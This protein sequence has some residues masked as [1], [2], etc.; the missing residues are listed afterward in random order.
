MGETRKLVTIVFADI[1]GSTRLGEELD[2]E[3]LRRVMERYFGDMRSVLEQHGGTVEKFI[4]DAVM[5]VFGIPAAHEDDALRAVRAAVE[6]RARLAE[7]NSE[8]TH[9]RGVMLAVR[10]GINT[11]EVVA[12]D[13]AGGQFYATGDAVNVAARLEQVADPGEILLGAETYQLV[14]DAVRVDGVEPLSL[15]GKA[16]V[17][18]AYRLVEVIEGAPGVA[19][20]FETRFV[21]REGQMAH[22]LRSFEHSVVEGAPVLITVL[23]AAGLGKTR[24]AEEFAAR[25]ARQAQVLQGRCLSYGEGITFWP[26]Q[27]ILRSLPVRPSDVPRP[28][29]AT[30]VEETFWA[31]RKLF[32]AVARERPLLIVVE[33]IHWAEPTLLDLI[34]HIVEWTQQAPMMLLCLARPDLLDRRPGWSGERIELE[35]LAESEAQ[36]LVRELALGL[37]AS[38]QARAVEVADGNP[39]FLEQMLALAA[40][41]TEAESPVPHTI[42]ALLAA[43][44][45]QLAADERK[46]LEAAS[47]VGK[48]FW[49]RALLHLLGPDTE[50]SPLLQGLIRKRLIQPEQSSF[51]DEDAFRFG[52]ILIREAAYR[53][54][55]KQTR[56]NLHERFADW[57][58]ERGTPYAEI[59]GYH[60]EQ[61]V[62]YQRDL[63]EPDERSL[64]LGERAAILLEQAGL[65]ALGRGDY[66][67]A[68]NLLERA[69]RLYPLEDARALFLAVPLGESLEATGEL[70]AAETLY[71]ETIA[72]AKRVGDRRAQWLAHLNNVWLSGQLHPGNW[73]AEAV[74]ETA[75]AAVE[76]FRELEDD[77]GLARAWRLRG[78]ADFAQCRYAAASEADERALFY[79]RRAGD[80]YAIRDAINSLAS[81]LY[82]GPTP[83]VE[84]IPRIEETMGE[85]AD[86]PSLKASSLFKLAALRAVQG[87]FQE[88]RSLYYQAKA[89]GEEMG[90]MFHLAASSAYV[91]EIGL[92]AGDAAFAER[93]LTAAYEKLEAMGERGVRSTLAAILAEALLI[94][95][96]LD[97]AEQFAD[98]ALSLASTDDIASQARG[99]AAKAK[100]LSARGDHEHAERL[101]RE[102]VALGVNTDDLFMQSQLLMALAEVLRRSGRDDGAI[103]VLQEAVAISERKGIVVTADAARAGLA[104]LHVDSR[105]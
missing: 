28:E 70:E 7:L 47:I 32:E 88:A 101:G 52:H 97:E 30:S 83:V 100:V 81:S 72:A 11:G 51:P 65:H 66:G 60:L 18:S 98:V 1:S 59:V 40:D 23:G 25:V 62:R 13:P 63:G 9:E 94:L 77:F 24:L 96:R 53:M 54:I 68:A 67:A 21:G 95:A 48:E 73:S 84:A 58:E 89:I 45:D 39:L 4:G 14:R 16:A 76:V 64:A 19:R 43:R 82:L 103:P 75:A 5:A 71:E 87:E 55:A 61:S 17:V 22:L 27:E 33:D 46:V 35:P 102:A 99:R 49:R 85:L 93:E 78:S 57:L 31:Y 90:L 80:E 10:T 69:R 44:L 92:L 34:E 3:A 104:E 50:V 86:N 56:A 12:G 29:D 37:D 38:V 42:Q 8:L 105:V 79:A 26:L 36:T 91:E 6:M 2:A 74:R 15:K 20:R 41:E